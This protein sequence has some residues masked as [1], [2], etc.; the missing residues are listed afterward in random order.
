MK[1]RIARCSNQRQGAY[2]AQ[3]Q[4][5]Q[6]G[7]C[8]LVCKALTPVEK[9]HTDDWSHRVDNIS[10]E[11]AH[12]LQLLSKAGAVFHVRTN[13]PQA[14]MVSLIFRSPSSTAH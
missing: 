1:R 8:G 6:H 12:L 5:L 7:L 9:A 13:Q 10:T 11:D 2:R 14:L 3:K 4:D